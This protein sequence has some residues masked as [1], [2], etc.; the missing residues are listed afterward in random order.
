M[1]YRAHLSDRCHVCDEE[2]ALHCR[3]CN[4]PLC[5]RHSAVYA[6]FTPVAECTGDMVVTC[7]RASGRSAEERQRDRQQRKWALSQG[8]TLR[9]G[10]GKAP[11]I[12]K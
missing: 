9:L 3:R 2:T 7:E 12:R 11:P 6:F 1:P 5:D 10:W 8:H 4:R